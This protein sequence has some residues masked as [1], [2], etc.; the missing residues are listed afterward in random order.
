[1]TFIYK[2]EGLIGLQYKVRITALSSCLE[3]LTAAGLV[4]CLMQGFS[5][6]SSKQLVIASQD[7]FRCSHCLPSLLDATLEELVNGLDQKLFTSVDLVNAYTDRINEVNGT[8][9]VVTELNPAALRLAR[10]ADARRASNSCLG[11]LDGIPVLIKNNIATKDKMNNTAGS[12]A[13]LGAKVPQ[14]STIAAK[15]RKAGA[16]ILGKTNLSQWANFR[17]DNTTNGW[18]AYGGQCT[19]AYYPNMDP[20]GSSSGSGVS[21]SIGLAWATLGTETSGSILS[22]GSVNNLV[23]IK[24]TVGLTSRHLVIPISEHQDTVGPLARTVTDAAYLLQA[25]AG[26]DPLDNYTSAIPNN[27]EIPDYTACLNKGAL[28]G[29]RIGVA[30]NAYAGGQ[31]SPQVQAAFET[32]VKQIQAA[33]ATIVE[34][35]FTDYDQFQNSSIPL[36][37]LEID[38]VTNVKQYLDLLVANPT[39]V[40]DLADI[41]AFT[42]KFKQEDYPARDIDLW[43]QAIAFG[44]NNTDPRFWPMYQQ[45]LYFGGIAGVLGA[46]SNY[47]LDAIILPTDVSP[48]LPALVGSPVVTVPLG[49][50]P[51]NQT[52]V[53]TGDFGNLVET[54]PHIPFGISFL[55]KRF[56][57]STIIGLAY[58]YEQ[59]THHRHDVKPAILPT[60]ELKDVIGHQS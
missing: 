13:L 33:G 41:A 57:E 43:Q 1:M 24:P 36:N 18:S 52:V 46:I 4:T 50:Y 44:Y 25:I 16:I 51:I 47:S 5:F 32:A 29:A 45:N 26:V 30:T 15:L 14:D 31:V 38:F 12:F 58:A 22:P 7:A 34:T 20:S 56:D 49:F 6:V 17:S 55:G 39:G 48:N 28:K 59:M 19:G 54:G 8:L 60:T 11:P 2:R 9:N 21:S 10:K 42:E 27:G 53:T 37:I 35:N 23:A 3:R 40:Q